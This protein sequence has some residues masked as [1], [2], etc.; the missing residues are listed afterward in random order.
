MELPE[1]H[2]TERRS[3]GIN[4]LDFA[5]DGGIPKGTSLLLS[6]QPLSGL[7][8]MAKQ[9][10]KTEDETGCYLMLDSVAEE[11]MVDV[12]EAGIADL[13]KKMTS[14]RNVVDSLSSVVLRHGIDAAVSLMTRDSRTIYG[15][16]NNILFIMYKGLHT[17]VEEMRLERA[18]DICMELR[19]DIQGNEIVR[20]LA[21]LKMQGGAVPDRLIPFLVTDKGLELSTTSR[22]V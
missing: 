16:G 7:D 8:L 14:T 22:V 21:I 17:P 20:S 11:G 19:Q 4:G 6:G 12:R 18:A 9:F 15:Q 5:L 10:W 2:K 1:I 13:P 3:T